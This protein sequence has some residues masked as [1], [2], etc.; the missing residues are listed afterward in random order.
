MSSRRAELAASKR[1]ELVA[2]RGLV[3]GVLVQQQ[4]RREVK[5]I[6]ASTQR[7]YR[8]TREL[9]LESVRYSEADRH[10]EHRRDSLHLNNKFLSFIGYTPRQ[11]DETLEDGSPLLSTVIIKRF[12]EWYVASSQGKIGNY[13]TKVTC[14]NTWHRLAAYA[15]RCTGNEYPRVAENDIVGFINGTLRSKYPIE[16][17]IKDPSYADEVDLDVLLDQL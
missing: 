7:G 2:S 17:V 8:G 15:A 9:L 4:Y 11:A 6:V 13:V 5:P 10:E 1:A 16:H 12:L 3:A 14:L